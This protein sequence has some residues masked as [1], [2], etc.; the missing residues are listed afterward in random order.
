MLLFLKS[1]L[2]YEGVYVRVVNKCVC[3]SLCRA[4]IVYFW[5]LKTLKTH[6]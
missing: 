5:Q 3:F 6:V 1:D 4:S 2:K